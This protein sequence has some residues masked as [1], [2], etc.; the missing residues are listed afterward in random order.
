MTIVVYKDDE[1]L[2]ND[3]QREEWLIRVWEI[4]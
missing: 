1:M 3:C 2:F 4:K